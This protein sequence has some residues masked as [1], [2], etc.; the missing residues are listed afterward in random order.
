MVKSKNMNENGKYPN[1]WDIAKAA[2]R[3]KF[4]HINVEK[5]EN[6]EI[7]NLT[8]YLKALEKQEQRTK[9]VEERK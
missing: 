9:L 1:W 8:L 2:L 4:L 5:Q 6:G 3:G 7:T